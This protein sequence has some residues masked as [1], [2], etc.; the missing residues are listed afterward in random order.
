MEFSNGTLVL[1]DT[2]MDLENPSRRLLSVFGDHLEIIDR[3]TMMGP[4]R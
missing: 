1:S 4:V 2:F 3:F